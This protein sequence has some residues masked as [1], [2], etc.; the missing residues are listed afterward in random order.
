[1]KKLQGGKKLARETANGAHANLV[2]V[3][4]KEDK[5]EES[6][7]EES[8]IGTTRKRTIIDPFEPAE[9]KR[10]KRRKEA[11]EI[12][13]ATDGTAQAVPQTVDDERMMDALS[14]TAELT[15]KKKKKKKKRSLLPEGQGTVEHSGEPGFANTHNAQKEGPLTQIPLDTLEGK[16][17][18]RREIRDGAAEASDAGMLWLVLQRS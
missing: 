3:K 10:K 17:P 7:A 13:E 15:P 9:K 6:S 18:L 11:E 8:R 14:A 4:K 5:D 16:K 1:V 2:G 12:K